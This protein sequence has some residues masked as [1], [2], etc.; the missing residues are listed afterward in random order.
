[1][2]LN[3]AIHVAHIVLAIHVVHVIHV[4]NTSCVRLVKACAS[5]E[6]RNGAK[7]SVQTGW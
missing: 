3:G 7:V 5:L 2:Q 1:M 6:T 4:V